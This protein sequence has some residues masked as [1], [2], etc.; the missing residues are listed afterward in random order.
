MDYVALGDSFSSG[1]GIGAQEDPCARSPLNYPHLV[2]AADPRIRLHDVTCAG[3]TPENVTWPQAD[4]QRPS[5]PP[6]ITP[7]R[8][9]LGPDTDLVTYSLG[10]NHALG[11]G[12]VAFWC[13]TG[14][15]GP[16]DTPCPSS[17]Q[18]DLPATTTTQLVRLTRDAVDAI[19]ERAPNARIV[20]IGYPQLFT[21]DA[22]C[23]AA[24]RTVTDRTW[25]VA[26][27]LAWNE[28]L[29]RAA[30]EKGVEFINAW[31]LS[32]GHDICS[33]DPWFNAATTS[34]AQQ[35]GAPVH[36]RA[37]W[38]RTVAAALQRLVSRPISPPPG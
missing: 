34:G 30:Q 13:L 26:L 31:D 5:A 35:D 36:P 8:D 28:A 27:N 18:E 17:A 1:I 11:Y 7:Q 22:S 32:R 4:P 38:H 2:A 37:V 24:P 19:G 3:A 10:A 9:A 12:S 21:A 33:P 15:E 6:T 20:V 16:S 29:A 25:V 14:A 23:P